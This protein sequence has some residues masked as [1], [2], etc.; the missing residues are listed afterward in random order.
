[1]NVLVLLSLVA[2]LAFAR[3]P[4]PQVDTHEFAVEICTSTTIDISSS[5]A[6]NIISASIA[7]SSA[8]FIEIYNADGTNIVNCAY[9]SSVST[10]SSSS[11]YGREVPSKAGVTWSI[12]L[13]K[14][15][16]IQCMTQSVTAASRCTITKC[17]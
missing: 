11:L 1:M 3:S 9:D 17:R 6:T 13:D 14:F 16:G 10:I 2:N 7:L 8:T 15:S 4:R 12:N 5:V